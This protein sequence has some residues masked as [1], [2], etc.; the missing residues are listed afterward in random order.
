MRFAVTLFLLSFFAFEAQAQECYTMGVLLRPTKAQADP[1]W[2]ELAAPIRVQDGSTKSWLAGVVEAYKRLGREPDTYG[3]ARTWQVPVY[4]G[5]CEGVVEPAPVPSSA[6]KPDGT[7]SQIRVLALDAA[8]TEYRKLYDKPSYVL[9]DYLDI[10]KSLHAEELT[11]LWTGTDKHYSCN[12]SNA[13]VQETQA[14]CYVMDVFYRPV[15][16]N[17][18]LEDDVYSGPIEV[19]DGSTFSLES[20]IMAG[21][22]RLGLHPDE[23]GISG[24][25]MYGPYPGCENIVERRGAPRVFVKPDGVCHTIEVQV[26]DGHGDYHLFMYDDLQFYVVESYQLIAE[27]L[28]DN[29]D[30]PHP[31]T[32]QYTALVDHY[33]CA[34]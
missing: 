32:V 17:D 18:S 33:A 8:G 26:L 5:N 24:T 20:G 3:I 29:V 6:V 31:I 4:G 2:D 19:E 10:V 23:W 9:S 21:Y 25:N 11:I 13:S 7:C 14:E 27:D 1:Q 28:E 34:D 30:L 12:D 15:G 22:E 16:A